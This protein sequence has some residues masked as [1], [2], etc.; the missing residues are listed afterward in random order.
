MNQILPVSQLFVPAAQYEP[1]SEETLLAQRKARERRQRQKER[2]LLVS[3]PTLIV[4][5]WFFI[6]VE[7]GDELSVV[8]WFMWSVFI[9]LAA[10][11]LN[12]TF[13]DED[14]WYFRPLGEIVLQRHKDENLGNR[15]L[16][17][18]LARV[19][20]TR[21]VLQ[22]D[23][24]AILAW[25]NRA[26]KLEERRSAAAMVAAAESIGDEPKGPAPA[27]VKG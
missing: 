6:G 17:L 4:A 12:S 18:N 7:L 15:E 1:Q 16:L 11:A 26:K 19:Q 3:V 27:P 10:Y 25:H 13:S 21:E 14:L 5:L 8:S 22:G 23:W 20:M 9:L 24:N 2:V